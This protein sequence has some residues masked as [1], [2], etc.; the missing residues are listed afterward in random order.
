[1]KRL[2]IVGSGI[3]AIG[4][5]YALRNDFEITIFEQAHRLG[6]HTHTHTINDPDG[7]VSVDTG[8]IV[9][10]TVTYP[11]L[12]RFFDELKVETH[13]SD[14]SFAVHNQSNNV[15]W[16]GINPG[17]LF[18]QRRNL[19]RPAFWS[20]LGDA[21]RF[22]R[23]AIQRLESGAADCSLGDFLKQEGFGEMF[24]RTYILPMGAAVWSTPANRMLDFPANSF[25]RF[26][27]N[28]GFLGMYTNHR[29]RSVC[30]GSSKYIEAFLKSVSPIVRLSSPVRSVVRGLD[31]ASVITD[32]GTET[33][34]AVLIATHADQALRVLETPTDL[35]KELLGSFQY[36]P[37]TAL[38][39]W[40]ESMLPPIKRCRASWNFV[41][42]S[43][44]EEHTTVYDMNRLQ[45][46]GTRRRYLVSINEFR[47]VADSK[48]L[49]EIQYDHPV[50]DSRAVQAQK[51]LD[52]L[53][54]NGPVFFSGSYF[55]YGFHEDGLWS[56]TQ[57]AGRILDVNTS[58]QLIAV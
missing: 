28:H 8:F 32:R 35:E 15:Q 48:I 6:G 50:F 23:T 31:Q 58:K 46:L 54:Q 52:R 37:N 53:N 10:N 39:H 9:Y 51:H 30:G 38:L 18:G 5:A 33:F 22:N 36:Q 12:T 19:V 56:A 24:I 20:M 25:I 29:W 21:A 26:F 43:K 55:R 1:M 57:A 17:T 40:D 2:G 11:L 3:S 44:Q 13:W 41:V 4:A 7:P 45:N 47:Q 49:A 14:M 16:A 42:D 27:H 34:D